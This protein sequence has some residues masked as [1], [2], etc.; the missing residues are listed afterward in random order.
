[1]NDL[2]DLVFP[3]DLAGVPKEL[4]VRMAREI[5]MEPDGTVPQLA[6]QLWTHVRQTRRTDLLSMVLDYVFA[7]KI[8]VSWYR[9]TSRDVVA[10]VVDHLA[11]KQGGTDYYNGVIE[12]DLQDLEDGRA[13]IIGAARGFLGGENVHVVRLLTKVRE[14]KEVEGLYV[15]R[16]SITAMATLVVNPSQGYVEL[17]AGST[18]VPRVVSRVAEL[19]RVPDSE[20]QPQLIAPFAELAEM[21][22][23]RL[24]GHLVGTVSK[25]DTYIG[26]LTEEQLDALLEVL[27]AVSDAI[28]DPEGTDLTQVII[29]ARPRLLGVSDPSSVPLPALLL[30]GFQTIGLRTDRESDARVGP[31]YQLLRPALQ[32]H[33]GFI[34]FPVED[35]PGRIEW[36][37]IRLGVTTNSVAFHTKASEAAVRKV[38]TVLF[39]LESELGRAR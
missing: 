37:T 6:S 16:R 31:L 3:V 1:M 14:T 24:Q 17:R 22:A 20:L 33:G 38:R 11:G 10:R 25:P 27:E 18:A 8:G 21:V 28:A 30:S 13:Y 32:H 23:D 12:L 35:P 9:P 39:D 26:N 2:E 7:G 34:R 19:L 29:D 4:L 36:H 15:R 5:G